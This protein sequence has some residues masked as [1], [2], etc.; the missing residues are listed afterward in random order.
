MLD[1]IVTMDKATPGD[2]LLRGALALAQRHQAFVTGAQVIVVYP[3]LL[4]VPAAADLLAS[5]EHAAENRRAWWLELC[6]KSGLGG[7]WEVIRGLAGEA[8]A[9]RSQLSDLVIGMLPVSNPASPVGFDEITRTLF[10]G[11]APMLLVPDTWSGDLLA[12]RVLI[13]WNGSS[14]AVRAIKAAL[15]LLRHAAMVQVLDGER[16]DLSQLAAT[17]LPLLDWLARHGVHA[18]YRQI[19]DSGHEAGKHLLDEARAMQADLLVMGAWGRS[20]FSELVLG[21]ATRHVLE[22]AHLPVLLSR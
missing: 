6:R 8:L 15:P 20:R 21:G 14:E 18:H 13:A 12:Q 9:K 1:F 2:G 16:D 17:R 5:E 22:N 7:E 11:V 19:A 10:A 4:A 3:A